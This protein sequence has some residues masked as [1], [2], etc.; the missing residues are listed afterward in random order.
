VAALQ[1]Q[2]IGP[3]PRHS[4]SRLATESELA[5]PVFNIGNVASIAARHDEALGWCEQSC[6]LQPT[7][8]SLVKPGGILQGLGGTTKPTQF[9]GIMG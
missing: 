5:T 8:A 3:K 2:A 9:A 1:D 6:R 4:F 7:V